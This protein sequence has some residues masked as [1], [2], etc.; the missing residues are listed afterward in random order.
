MTSNADI[1]REACHVIWTEGQID[2]VPEFYSETS[3]PTMLL[4]IGERVLRVSTH[5][6]RAF[7][8]DSL[9]TVRRSNS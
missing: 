4:Q 6:R 7:D 9:T 5:S 1:V 8:W 2:R 3:Q